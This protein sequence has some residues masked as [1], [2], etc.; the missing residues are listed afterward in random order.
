MLTTDVAS[1]GGRAINMGKLIDLM[2]KYPRAR[3]NVKERESMKTEED[4]N[5]AR[6]FGQEFFDGD[7]SHGYGGYQYNPKYWQQVVPTFQKYY[8][9]TAGSRV[10]DV[11]CA[12]GFMVY[13][14]QRLIPGLDIRGVDISEY[15]IE[16][17]KAEVK[18]ITSIADARELPFED[19]SFDLVI[20]INTLH[21]LDG[22]DL[23]KGFREVVR[24][25]RGNAFATVDAFNTEEEKMAMLAWNLTAKTILSADDWIA[26][27][28]KVGYTGD[29]Y[30]F[31]P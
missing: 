7:R 6:R 23:V 27:F 1:T 26:F 25:S 9:L 20:S 2:E 16:N 8:G 13:D 29:Y 28:K 19:D 10:L 18:E 5:I 3:R 31:M 15:A 12:K 11:G 30:W 24:V 4:R 21:N 17:A 14:F 22:D